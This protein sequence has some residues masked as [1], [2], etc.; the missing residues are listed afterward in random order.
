MGS[1]VRRSSAGAHWAWRI[2][3]REL[4]C[5]FFVMCIFQLQAARASVLAK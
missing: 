4:L 2:R 1:N 5:P 3:W